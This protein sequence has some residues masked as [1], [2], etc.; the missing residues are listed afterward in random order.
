MTPAF[1]LRRALAV[2]MLLV[3]VAL[4]LPR[5]LTHTPY[6]RL[7]AYVSK[8]VVERVIG[9]PAKGLLRPGDLL[10]QIDTLDLRLDG[11]RDSLR[12]HG[13]PPGPF[14]LVVERG[15]A[16]IPMTV[17]PVQMNAWERLRVYWYPIVAVVAAPLVAFLL[18]WRRPDL[19]TAWVF[20]WFSVLQGLGV[21]WSLYQFPQVEMTAPFRMYLRAYEWLSWLYPASFVH[22]MSVFPRS[23]W[24]PGRRTRSVWL[25]LTVAAYLAPL[26][27]WAA[28][29][30]GGKSPAEG[31]YNWYQ[32]IAL[33]VGILSLVERYAR[34]G[35]GWRPATH[36]RVLAMMSA[37]AVLSSAAL[38]MVASSRTSIMLHM[39]PSACAALFHRRVRSRGCR[40]RSSRCAYLIAGG[41][42]FDPRRLVADGLP[43]ALLSGALAAIYLGVVLLGQ[44][45]FSSATGEQTLVFSVV[46]ALIL[47][48][49]FAPLRTRAARDRPALR[50]GVRAFGKRRAPT[51]SALDHGEVR[52]AVGAAPPLPG[53]AAWRCCWPGERRCRRGREQCSRLRARRPGRCWPVRQQN[54]GL[55][56]LAGRAAAEPRRR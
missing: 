4:A 25:W 41:P 38:S 10:V 13:M 18:V 30:H 37:F 34:S 26:G 51:S 48:F 54:E 22:F 5:F 39:P 17:P 50:P 33:G 11:A 53:C 55:P 31:V 32:A 7:G 8:G 56:R 2:T 9:P 44:R 45:L 19:P 23:R 1:P 28:Y 40:R 47:A 42:I 52:A 35:P 36:Q 43:Y 3:A 49:A 21:M 29:A 24:Q 16:L 12:A 15:G 20:L 14:R 27:L 6:Q 46:A